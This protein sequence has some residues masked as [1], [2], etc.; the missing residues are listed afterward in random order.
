MDCSNYTEKYMSLLSSNQCVHIAYDPTKSLESNVQRRL[1]KIKLK[2]SK[3]EYK[4]LYRTGSCPGKL[5][6]TAKIH[7]LSVN[8]AINDLP[9]GLIVSN[10]NTARYSLVKYLPKLLSPL[11]QSRNTVK[12]TKEFIG[13]LKQQ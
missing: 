6:G 4:K 8:G 12:N 13:E 11:R 9:V 7:K 1:R 10:L 3:Q 2:L 5:Y